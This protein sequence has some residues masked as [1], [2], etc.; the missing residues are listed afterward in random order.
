MDHIEVIDTDRQ[1][2]HADPRCNGEALFCG[3]MLDIQL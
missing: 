1:H 2:K 3:G